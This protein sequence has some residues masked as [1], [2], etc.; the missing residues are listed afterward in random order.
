MAAECNTYRR[1]QL[2]DF[3]LPL[4]LSPPQRRGLM[5]IFHRVLIRAGAQEPFGHPKLAMNS[6]GRR[7]FLSRV[8]RRAGADPD[9]GNFSCGGEVQWRGMIRAAGMD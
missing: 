6:T 9:S 8:E 3:A 4:K 5:I 7:P 1:N 2:G